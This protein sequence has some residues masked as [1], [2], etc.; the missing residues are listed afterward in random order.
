MIYSFPVTFSNVLESEIF[1]YKS[2][3]Y[4]SRTTQRHA[5]KAGNFY[6]IQDGKNSETL[7]RCFLIPTGSL[8]VKM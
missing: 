2:S 7:E 3:G 4:L 5:L 6:G 1:R 8:T